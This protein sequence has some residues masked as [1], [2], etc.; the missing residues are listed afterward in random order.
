M[1]SML[2]YLQSGHVS[3]FQYKH[4]FGQKYVLQHRSGKGWQLW[5]TC[6]FPCLCILSRFLFCPPPLLPE[7]FSPHGNHWCFVESWGEGLLWGTICLLLK[8]CI[9]CFH[10]ESL[11]IHLQTCLI[12]FLAL[13]NEKM[14]VQFTALP[15]NADTGP[16]ALSFNCSPFSGIC[17]IPQL[18]RKGSSA[19]LVGRGNWGMALG[20][21]L[22]QN[23]FLGRARRKS[24]IC[25]LPP[26]HVC[27][28]TTKTIQTH[29]LKATKCPQP[30]LLCQRHSN[31]CIDAIRLSYHAYFQGKK[32]S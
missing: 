10:P 27:V 24:L 7:T 5:F 30:P 3:V 11:H 23:S 26:V 20:L 22:V 18:H 14:W 28:Q 31:N 8:L 15:N 25:G 29:F 32:W 13:E 16:H 12:Q 19:A 17:T 21:E 6:H 2:I 9:V 4:T 1:L